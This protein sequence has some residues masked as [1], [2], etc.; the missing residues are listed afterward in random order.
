[1]TEAAVP[2]A[3]LFGHLPDGLFRLLSGRARSLY[4]GLLVHLEARVFRDG[5]DA[6]RADVTECIRLFLAD[7]DLEASSV[8][9]GDADAALAIAR[10]AAAR[11]RIAHDRLVET[12]WLVER[13]E[14]YRRRVDMDA[15]ARLLL[16]ALIEIQDGTLR[17]YG[18]EVLQVLSL[19][20]SARASPGERSEA[21]RNAARSSKYFLNHLRGVG[22]AMRRAEEAVLAQPSF[23]G[24]IG[25]F[26]DDFVARHLIEDFSRLHTGSNPFRFRPRIMDMAAEMEGDPLLMA[27]L[28]EAY[29]REGRAPDGAR[30]AAMVAADLAGVQDTFASLDGYLRVIRETTRR[31]EARVVNS[32]RFLDRIADGA[33]GRARDAF[34]ALA[35]TGHGIDEH[36]PLPVPAMPGALPQGGDIL[37]QAQA[38]RAR[39]A[40]PALRR[41]P[42]DPAIMLYQEAMNAY[43]LKGTV[44]PRRMAEY[45]DAAMA[46]Q[47]RV[48]AEAL[49]LQSLDD[50]FVFER[51][52]SLPFIQGVEF[53]GLYEVRPL[54]GRFENPWIECPN[55][56]IARSAAH[57]R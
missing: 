54:P 3:T 5:V 24:M 21:L 39:A 19:L 4:A 47:E 16:D 35:A 15:P 18:G 28:A 22:S 55:F 48:R 41:L 32:L 50:F 1:M 11:A 14:G 20:E 26:F 29:L 9:D 6:S 44:T 12:G 37:F 17:S 53:S 46:G 45:L 33:A 49:P 38:R 52:R 10:D 34:V 51:L 13:R 23:G 42:P 8:A 57:V 7:A 2:A 43:R 27:Q 30:A 31:L 40:A 36:V 25:A 56:E